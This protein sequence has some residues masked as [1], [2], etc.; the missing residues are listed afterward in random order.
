[1]YE[2]HCRGCLRWQARPGRER[3]LAGTYTAVRLSGHN[4]TQT[5]G[6]KSHHIIRQ[7]LLYSLNRIV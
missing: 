5:R 1:M 7:A 3:F 6:E 4:Q 2:Q